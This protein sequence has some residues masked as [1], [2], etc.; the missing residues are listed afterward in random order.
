GLLERRADDLEVERGGEPPGDRGVV[1]HLDRV[2]L[3]E[4]EREPL[5]QERHEVAGELRAGPGDP[6]AVERT[7]RDDAIAPDAD[8]VGEPDRVGHAVRGAEP[9]EDP[10]ALIGLTLGAPEILIE[11]VVDGPRVVDLAGGLGGNE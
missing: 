6:E 1:V 2:L 7:A 9:E 10:D 11:V 5:P 8:G 4:A 3:L